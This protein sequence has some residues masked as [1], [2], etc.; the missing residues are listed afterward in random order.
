MEASYDELLYISISHWTA[1]IHKKAFVLP[2]IDDPVIS[3]RGTYWDGK[4]DSR[5]ALFVLKAQE[6]FLRIRKFYYRSSAHLEWPYFYPDIFRF[7]AALSQGSTKLQIEWKD[8]KMLA[9]GLK[10]SHLCATFVIISLLGLGM[11]SV[12]KY[13]ETQKDIANKAADERTKT[14]IAEQHSNIIN[15]LS[16]LHAL[17]TLVKNMDEHDEIKFPGN[18]QFINKS[19][20]EKVTDSFLNIDLADVVFIDDNYE[21]LEWHLESDTIVIRANHVVFKASLN[22]LTK[23]GRE[24]VFDAIRKAKS[25]FQKNRL[26]LRIDAQVI[27]NRVVQADVVGMGQ[28]RPNSKRMHRKL[29]AIE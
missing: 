29:G 2:I 9:E 23:K 28:P 22:K 24:K 1:D 25:K 7:S 17:P 15:S 19:E 3:L 26:Q 21:V 10:G 4:I 14:I 27:G 11:C 16:R 12:N 8:L 6:D 13:I 18:P 5:V 20:A